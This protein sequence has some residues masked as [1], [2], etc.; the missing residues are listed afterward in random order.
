MPI[1]FKCPHCQKGLSVKE[2]L[3]GKRAA[4]PACK[5]ALTI[6][7]AAAAPATD[8]EALAASALT[9]EPAALAEAP[10][11]S[12]IDLN[13]PNCDEPIHMSIELGGKQAP[14]PECKRIIKVPM[15]V[16]ID[17]K[18]W[19]KV[20]ARGPLLAR[21]DDGPAPEGAW[22]STTKAAVSREAL[23]EADAI[24]IVKDPLTL[25]QKIKRGVLT[26]AGVGALVFGWFALSHSWSQGL[27]DRAVSQA[28]SFVGGKDGKEKLR[29][30]PEA[31]GEVYRAL[32]EMYLIAGKPEE[33]RDSFRKARAKAR[34]AS[35]QAFER[36]ATLMDLALA[37]V[38]LGG[39]TAEVEKKTR[40][41]WD[42]ASR[43]WEQ[44]LKAVTDAGR[45][46]AVR[47]VC[48]KV[49][50]ARAP[51]TLALGLA[52]DSL[53]PAGKPG[54]KLRK[55]RAVALLVALRNP[56]KASSILPAPKAP[57]IADLATRLVHDAG[58]KKQPDLTYAR[59][60]FL[61][62][63]KDPVADRLQC[64]LSV[65]ATAFDRDNTDEARICVSKATELIVA[66]GKE[67]ASAPWLVLEW[68]LLA[69]QTEQDGE[70]QKLVRALREPALRGR[71]E[72]AK[73]RLQAQESKELSEES[74]RQAVPDKSVL[75]HGLALQA[76]ARNRARNGSGSEVLAAID[77]V[78]PERIR[79]L[80]FAGVA[81][82]LEKRGK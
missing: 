7:A 44:T 59:G 18:D 81:M 71:L 9:D 41:S 36:D 21:R 52:S 79:P 26:A 82:G 80:G 19:R 11:P 34:V 72:L 35:G 8:I 4:C 58:W 78:E 2:Q 45:V 1:K 32:G 60:F 15:P 51:D 57:A 63:D 46:A 73:Y 33:A 24:P 16:K 61:K 6:P 42:D 25:R 43:Q 28:L 5:K 67:T 14:C 74:W 3:A 17:P 50:L 47:Q 40:L 29:T 20:E 68:G 37:Q 27:K 53:E 70:F 10:E 13:C 55:P 54:D 39:G 48:R 65:A 23:E 31:A 77:S 75:A 22:G 64:L 76:Y 30:T 56:E 49:L 66:N 62:A 38:D 69:L 12:T